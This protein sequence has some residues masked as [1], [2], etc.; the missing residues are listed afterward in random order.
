MVRRDAAKRGEQALQAL[1]RG[2]PLGKIIE[3]DMLAIT[4]AAAI[5]AGGPSTHERAASLLAT[6]TDPELRREIVL[7]LAATRDP[8]LADKSLAMLLDQRLRINELRRMFRPLAAHRETRDQAWKWLQANFDAFRARASLT[9]QSVLPQHM[10]ALCSPEAVESVDA[11]FAPRLGSIVGGP[12]SLTL[13]KETIAACA[14]MANSQ[15]ESAER[16][17]GTIKVQ[18][19]PLNTAA[20]T[21]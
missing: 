4:L 2:Q 18:Q 20:K 5:D 19:A 21:Q 15:R 13:A 7:G 1:E 11:F 3:T 10:E 9:E 12:R 14:A 17:L 16:F 6:V 8:A